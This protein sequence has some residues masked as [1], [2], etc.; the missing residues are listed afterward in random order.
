L[1]FF[2][3]FAPITFSRKSFDMDLFLIIL[4][5]LLILLG[6]LGCIL[7]VLPGVPLSY[8]GILL[9]HFSSKADFSV[10]FL[11]VWGIIV[12]LAQLLDYIFPI[13]G[14]KKFG[15]S[16]KGIWGSSIGMMVGLFF[17]PWGIIFGPFL[18]AVIGELMD[19]KNH[20][21][22]MK[23]GFGTFAGMLVNMVSKLIIAGF[24]IFYYLEAL[25]KMI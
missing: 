24:F 8:I 16:K 22:A 4:S 19:G 7:P 9:L 1:R 23:A 5:G 6:F 17:G 18:G 12:L 11:V 15:G 13:W 21:D 20:A 2:P 3:I 14:A 10:R 25:V